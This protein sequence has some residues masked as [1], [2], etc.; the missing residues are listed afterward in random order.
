MNGPNR[1]EGHRHCRSV[2]KANCGSEVKPGGL[3]LIQW[4]RFPPQCP[5]RNP[6]NLVDRRLPQSVSLQINYPACD[7]AMIISGIAGR[8]GVQANVRPMHRKRANHGASVTY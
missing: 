3:D 6:R 5:S 4:Q 8:L 2:A 1:C 7:G